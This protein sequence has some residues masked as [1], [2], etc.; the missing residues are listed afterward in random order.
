MRFGS[1]ALLLFLAPLLACCATYDTFVPPPGP[2]LPT[3]KVKTEAQAVRLGMNCGFEKNDPDHWWANLHDNMWYV[4]WESGLNT[5][6]VQVA[7]SD[8]AILSCDVND[9]TL[10]PK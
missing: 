3:D 7:K 8:G 1:S 6:T 9:D 4:Y 5:I 10:L 2:I